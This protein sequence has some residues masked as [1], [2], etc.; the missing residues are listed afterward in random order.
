M[1]AE[2]E[3]RL[4]AL[5]ERI[6]TLESLLAERQ[7]PDPT[8][9]AAPPAPV[10]ASA[11][12]T[13][14]PSRPSAPRPAPAL[15]EPL[16]L[17]Q[18]LGGRLLAWVGGI[19]VVLAAVFFLVMAVHNGW[20]D[21]TARVVLAFLGSTILLSVGV[22]L[23]ERRGRTQ[24]ALAAVAAA[25]AALYAS[26]TAATAVYGLVSP[27]V[28]LVLAGLVGVAGTAI[29]VRWGSPVVAGVGLVGALLG[30][31]LVDAGT[32]WTSLAFMA[33]ALVST[34]AV[35]VWKR[36]DW[37]AAAAYLVSAPQAAH[38]IDHERHVHIGASLAVIAL[39]WIVFVV[40]ALGYEA[41]V[42]TSK[43][44][45]SSALLLLVNAVV[46]AA[47]GWA[48]LDADGNH[49][50]ATAWVLAVAAAHV[51]LFALSRRRGI[52]PEVG[53]LV[54]GEGAALAAV[55]LALALHGTALV[56]GWSV[57]GIVVAWAARRGGDRRG[58]VAAAI[59]LALATGQAVIVEAPPQALAYGL[60]SVWGA[61]TSLLLVTAA[62]LA[63]ARL[64][65]ADLREEGQ[66]AQSIA[67]AL[68]VYLGSVLVVEL[69]GA[70]GSTTQSSQL[71]LSAFWAVL[72]FAALVVGLVRD[73]RP[74]RIAGFA[75]L[76]LAVGKVFL[77]DLAAL[78]SAW[79]VASFLAL[80]LLLLAGAFAYQRAR[81]GTRPRA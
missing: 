50:G 66:I 34:V 41:R 21:E 10:P 26:T 47:A 25:L 27:G 33:V 18:L 51:L 2:V 9:A 13:P 36:W 7:A 4:R 52:S 58:Y 76:G 8:P 67:A 71:A 60:D 24:A 68:V 46:T 16:D 44:R 31:V 43:L 80:G 30:P 81:S 40:A 39:F 63:L 35:L 79:R 32:S 3:T 48:V 56:A 61:T 45:I 62:W 64:L 69:A 28:G 12:P 22:W 57:A 72:G 42:P 74:L 73:A 78:E 6:A 37:L 38:W 29:A 49:Q 77:V 23:Y 11:P 55:G 59:Y 20:I 54:A 14:W 1:E 5:E 53:I 65:P 15:R 70:D 17:E 19:A 75:L